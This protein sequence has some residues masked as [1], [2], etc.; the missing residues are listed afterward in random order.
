M[1]VSQTSVSRFGVL[2]LIFSGNKQCPRSTHVSWSAGPP[3]K[4]TVAYR[5]PVA[6]DKSL[7]SVQDEYYRDT[8]A[9]ST[10]WRRRRGSRS[11]SAEVILTCPKDADQFLAMRA[12]RV[13]S[14]GSWI[15][16]DSS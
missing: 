14:G 11:G 12:N 15:Q 4:V 8:I 3:V 1:E 13:V 9:T 16:P 6:L 7:L 5:T 2:A 10:T